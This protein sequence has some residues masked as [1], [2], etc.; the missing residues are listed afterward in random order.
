MAQRTESIEITLHPEDKARI[1]AAAAAAGGLRPITWARAA[2]M[3]A[4]I[5]GRKA[6]AGE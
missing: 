3:I 1:E 6:E 5:N 2:L 4:A